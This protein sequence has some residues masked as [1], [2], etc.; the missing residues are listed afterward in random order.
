MADIESNRAQLNAL[1]VGH[2][3]ITSLTYEAP[4]FDVE[5]SMDLHFADGSTVRI[6]YNFIDEIVEIGNPESDPDQIVS[7]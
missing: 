3:E 2:G 7:F 5:H 4:K 1:F 6:V